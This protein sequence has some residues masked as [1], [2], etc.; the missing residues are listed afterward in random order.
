MS[1]EEAMRFN[2]GKVELSL[3]PKSLLDETARVLMFGAQKYDRNNWKKGMKYTSIYDSLQ[4]HLTAFL[5]GEDVD[6]ESGL[7]H[8]AHAS[9]NIAFLIEYHTKQTGEDDR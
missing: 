3:L 2:D 5:E 8:L 6:P 1:K 7:L 9:C 4:R